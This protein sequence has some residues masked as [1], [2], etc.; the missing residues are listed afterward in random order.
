MGL[1]TGVTGLTGS[2][3]LTGCAFCGV[4]GI[5]CLLLVTF[6]VFLG[7][8]LIMSSYDTMFPAFEEE[9][10]EEGECFDKDPRR[11][12][13]GVGG[14]PLF[15]MWEERGGVPALEYAFLSNKWREGVLIMSLL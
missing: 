12:L 15:I 10:E 6:G 3:T 9:E 4:V 5:C 2:V 14:V 13:L 8:F 11:S 7:E 1:I